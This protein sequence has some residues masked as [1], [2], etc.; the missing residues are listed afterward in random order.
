[1]T[2]YRTP[3]LYKEDFYPQPGTGE[4]RT[5]IPAFLGYIING[6]QEELNTP[7]RL[8]HWSQFT[9]KIGAQL[10]E[11]GY[12][13]HAVHGFFQNGGDLCYIIRLAYS[14][15]TNH[16]IQAH[17]AGLQ[18]LTTLDDI[19]L[20][21]APDIFLPSR[22][23]D[24]L[25]IQAEILEYCDHAGD[26]F[27]ILD[28]LPDSV[29]DVILSQRA[30]LKSKNGTLYAPW[31][32]IQ[33]ISDNTTA[34]VPPCGHVAGVYAR[35][36]RDIGVHKAPANEPLQGVLNLETI[37]TNQ[38]QGELNSANINCLRAFPGRG[39]RIWGAR[40]LSH[41]PTWLYISVRRLFLTT[42][43]WIDRNLVNV[44]FEPNDSRLWA[45]IERELSIYFR[46]LHQQGALKGSSPKEAFFVKCNAELNPC[47]VRQAGQ[48][49][50]EIGL[51]PA[52]PNEFVVVR[53]VHKTSSVAEAGPT[54]PE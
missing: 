52:A 8:T 4:I 23:E 37:L 39:I 49:N 28:A 54:Q 19:D 6:S 43:R 44:A 16:H 22:R 51:A 5:G 29:P 41:D 7:V 20:I 46:Q 14:H 53:I 25:T 24:G 38:Q 32:C 40:T 3:G 27:A 47:E 17:R 42:A 31:I 33:R 48:V 11:E 34:W 50:T 35:S 26:R 2:V 21:C 9:A 45:R 1:M 18:V 15:E 10:P 12:L 30:S 36:D 13:A